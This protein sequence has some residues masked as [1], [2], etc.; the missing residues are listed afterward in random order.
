MTSHPVIRLFSKK[1]LFGTTCL[2]FQPLA[3]Y[4]IRK[5]QIFKSTISDYPISQ[6]PQTLEYICKQHYFKL[7]ILSLIFRLFSLQYMRPWI[8][9]YFPSIIRQRFIL[10]LK[11]NKCVNLYYLSELTK[12]Y[13][14]KGIIILFTKQMPIMCPAPRLKTINKMKLILL[15]QQVKNLF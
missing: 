4:S 2:N 15:T 9:S 10:I 8:Y 7:S 1:D 13:L 3:Y 12:N 11:L 6:L 14:K 5:C